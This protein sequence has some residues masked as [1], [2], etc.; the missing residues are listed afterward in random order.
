MKC[1]KKKIK[2]RE[3]TLPDIKISY[4]ATGMTQC[5]A[6]TGTGTGKDN[7]INRIESR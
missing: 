4:R 1:M 5:D 2:E 3:L 7:W 6:G